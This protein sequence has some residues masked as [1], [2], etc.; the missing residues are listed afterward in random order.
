M[1]C[2]TTFAQDGAYKHAAG[3]PTLTVIGIPATNLALTGPV[4]F[5]KVVTESGKLA[6]P[7]LTVM[8]ALAE[9]DSPCPSTC[10]CKR[11]TTM[12]SFSVSVEAVYGCVRSGT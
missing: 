2:T 1:Y 9:Q 12:S 5:A 10:T 8:T 3:E 6:L 7:L 11:V 4:S